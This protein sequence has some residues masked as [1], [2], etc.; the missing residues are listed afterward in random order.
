MGRQDMSLIQTTNSQI[1]GGEVMHKHAWFR[2]GFT[3]VVAALALS[4]AGATA[5]AQS[6]TT[7]KQTVNSPPAASAGTTVVQAPPQQVQVQPTPTV[8]SSKQVVTETHSENF[9]GTI[10][11]NVFFGAIAGGL[12][13]GAIYFIDRD[14]IR[15]VTVAYWASGGA[16]VGAAVGIVELSMREDRNERAVSQLLGGKRANVAFVPRLVNVRF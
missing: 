10:A 16:L 2:G 6:V 15:P 3:V 11:K 7:E 14:N 12:V 4:F 9:M 8:N 13:G 1:Q 5:Q